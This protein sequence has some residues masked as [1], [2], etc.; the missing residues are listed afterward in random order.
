[1]ASECEFT[2]CPGSCAV[3]SGSSQL[4]LHIENSLKQNEK[5]FYF[6]R[7]PHKPMD[8][9]FLPMYTRL[10]L[11]LSSFTLLSSLNPSYPRIRHYCEWMPLRRTS[12]CDFNRKLESRHY[13]ND[14]CLL[15]VRILF[16]FQIWIGRMGFCWKRELVLIIQNWIV[17]RFE[18]PLT[19]ILSYFPKTHFLVSGCFF[20]LLLVF[21]QDLALNF[22]TMQFMTTRANYDEWSDFWR[23]MFLPNMAYWLDLMISKLSTYNH[24]CDSDLVLFLT[25]QWASLWFFHLRNPCNA[26][27]IQLPLISFSAIF[28]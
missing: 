6:F 17:I 5:V 22:D 11:L 21:F 28:L 12:G 20:F 19:K 9:I 16:F 14:L 24:Y 23:L 2:I 25:F 3:G 18:H 10:S 1:M 26:R 15:P 8:I 27:H 4:S 13:A 7:N